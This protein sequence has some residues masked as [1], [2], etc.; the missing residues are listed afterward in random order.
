MEYP[1]KVS[2]RNDD[3]KT[4]MAQLLLYHLIPSHFQGFRKITLDTLITDGHLQ[5]NI[6]SPVLKDE[7][8]QGLYPGLGQDLTKYSIHLGVF[9]PYQ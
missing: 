3:L 6:S 8:D 9:L 5:A 1:L 4:R 7:S 2:S